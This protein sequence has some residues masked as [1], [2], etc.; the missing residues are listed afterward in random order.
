MQ[1][2]KTADTLTYKTGFEVGKIL[3]LT[4]FF[5]IFYYIFSKKF[6]I[7]NL[8]YLKYI[9]IIFVAYIILRII[10]KVIKRARPE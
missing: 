10:L 6:N 8:E 4:I 9:S 1:F 7:I 2:I 5:S 3:G